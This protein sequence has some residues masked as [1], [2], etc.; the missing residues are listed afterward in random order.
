MTDILVRTEGRERD[1]RPL[2]N[3]EQNAITVE[4][5]VTDQIQL[6]Q[7]RV[8]CAWCTKA[9]LIVL[10]KACDTA[11]GHF[12]CSNCGQWFKWETRDGESRT[13]RSIARPKHTQRRRT[14]WH[15]TLARSKA[16]QSL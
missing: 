15:E 10:D 8:K 3:W 1:P 11:R 4:V 2:D 9:W 16:E 13:T 12:I 6:H 7:I 5:E 14:Q